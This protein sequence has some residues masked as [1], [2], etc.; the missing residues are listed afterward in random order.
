MSASGAATDL[1][2][3]PENTPV[4]MPTTVSPLLSCFALEVWFPYPAT[5]NPGVPDGCWNLAEWGFSTNQGQLFLV[6]NPAQD[7]QRGVYLPI[8]GDAAIQFT[9][10]M[11][12]F[13]T[14]SNDGGFLHFG[15]VQDAPFSN[16]NGGYLSYQQP[17]PGASSPI[18]V[19]VNGTNQ[20]TQTVLTLEKGFQQAIRLSV[21]EDLLVVFLDNVPAGEPISLPR[22]DRAFWIG[23]VL[24]GKAELDVSLTDFV[25]TPP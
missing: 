10:Q 1:P 2:P 14:R 20:G 6:H 17:S 18:R 12:E 15:I 9:L 23:Y 4:L 16:Y 8:S 22:A 13:R 24:P 7:Q 11:N 19:L 21:E 25:V 5:L 3:V